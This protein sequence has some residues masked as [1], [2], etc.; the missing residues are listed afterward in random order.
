MPPPVL[1]LKTLE[2]EKTMGKRKASNAEECSGVWSELIKYLF[3]SRELY[4]KKIINGV[5]W[6]WNVY[7]L[8]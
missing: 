8:I 2:P 4:K 6:F 3:P 5:F 7:K 1:L